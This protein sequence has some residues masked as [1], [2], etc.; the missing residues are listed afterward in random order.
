MHHLALNIGGQIVKKVAPNS[1]Q[2]VLE[3]TLRYI[4]IYLRKIPGCFTK[5]M[6]NT[7]Q[8]FLAQ[9]PYENSHQ[10]LMVVDIQGSENKSDICGLALHREILAV[11]VAD[12]V[13]FPNCFL[14]NIQ[15]LLKKWNKKRAKK[16]HDRR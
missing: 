15:L 10:N 14:E 8:L 11:L 1:C 9:F 16:R 2:K 12:Y 4:V 13:P 6:N 7:G 5:Y 3:R